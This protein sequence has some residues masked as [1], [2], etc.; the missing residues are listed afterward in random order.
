MVD[1]RDL[2]FLSYSRSEHVWRDRLRIFL[3][4]YAEEHGLTIWADVYDVQVG[5]DWHRE[6]RHALARTRLAVFLVSQAFLTSRFIQEEETGREVTRRRSPVSGTGA[7]RWRSASPTDV[8]SWCSMM[9]GTERMRWR[10]KCWDRAVAI[11]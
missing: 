2:I 4:L 7:T 1:G 10:F 6:T 3:Q 11:S 9:S 8:R 5:D